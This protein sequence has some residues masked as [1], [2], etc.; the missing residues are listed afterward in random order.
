MN[1]DNNERLWER[2]EQLNTIGIALSAEH[3]TP[4]L[5][6][7]ILL[8]AKEITQADGCSIYKVSKEKQEVQ[9]EIMRT[10]SLD[11]AM[12]GTT[13]IAVP[14]KPIPLFLEDGQP[15]DRFVVTTAVLQK[16]TIAISDAYTAKAFDFSGTREFDIKNN[17]RSCS[18]LTIPMKNHE[19]DVIGVLQLI[20]AKDAETGEVIAFTDADQHLA[21]SLA[22]QAAM[23]LTN[24]RLI[25]EQKKLFNA[26]I[27]LI[28]TAIDEKSPYT[29]S[30][31]ER[32]PILTK[33]LAE[34]AD[35]A[36]EGVFKDFSLTE[37]HYYELDVASW[38]H[39]CGKITTPEYVMDKATKLETIVDRID[40][41]CER[42]EILKRDAKVVMQGRMIEALQQGDEPSVQVYETEYKKRLMQ[43]TDD[44]HFLRKCNS[45]G[46]FMCPE[47]QARVQQIG[48]YTWKNEQGNEQPLLSEDEIENLCI[49]KGT[50]NERERK[51]INN[52]VSA[53]IK[54]LDSL[55]FPKALKNVPKYAGSHHE[56]PNGSGYPNKLSGD[57]FA[58]PGRIM[59]I[60]DIFEALTDTSRPYKKGMPI[61]K[62]LAILKQMKND[63][64]I[65]ADLLDLFISQKIYLEYAKRY[66]S[67]AQIDMA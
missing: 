56:C 42:I 43:L 39:D 51:V 34:A 31:C 5:L 49:P 27:K 53:T 55:P 23:A 7:M 60:A 36:Q 37:D 29:G 52:H 45:G 12:G 8:G 54:M 25:D 41:V 4:R 11:F 57:A 58:I 1:A 47:D 35:R 48:A 46:E 6:E 20:N 64:K 10:D 18:F 44:Q 50:L 26:F 67:A 28:A 59:A 24:Q 14:Q 19:N 66:L 3:H 22:S 9:L 40:T 32:V 30:H 33:M 2:I 16:K 61:S 63:N 15:N 13:G 62:A 17:Y 65:D 21:E 38:L